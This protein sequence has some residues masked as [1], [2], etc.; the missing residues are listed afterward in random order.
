MIDTALIVKC[1][2]PA[3]TPAMVEQFLAAAGSDDPLAITV[4]SGGRLL[5]VPKARTPAE[6]LDLVGQYVDRASVRIG[7]TQ[8]PLGFGPRD[9]GWPDENVMDSCENLR[10][11]TAMFAK[12]AR[13]VTRW[14]GDQA[15]QD[16]LPQMFE[17]AVRAWAT[18]KFE[19]VDVFRASDPGG[20]TFLPADEKP[21]STGSP[22]L[23]S[24]APQPADEGA[25]PGADGAGIS[26]IRIDL[27]RIGVRD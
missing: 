19:R 9:L 7:I 3:L 20:P 13:V 14:Y 23:A 25:P 12:I 1:A 26:E 11:G 8:Y 27:S 21:A 4:R 17:D 5:L 16:A 6:A 15:G 18:G 22:A 24:G 2:D 10:L